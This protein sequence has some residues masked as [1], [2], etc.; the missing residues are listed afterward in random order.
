MSVT[1]FCLFFAQTSKVWKVNS[2]SINYYVV[3]RDIA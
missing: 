1:M 2:T 3:V